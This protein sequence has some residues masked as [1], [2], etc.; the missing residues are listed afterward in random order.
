MF[1][2]WK[3]KKENGKFWYC[4]FLFSP[5]VEWEL[6]DQSRD[7][8]LPFSLQIYYERERII[9]LLTSYEESVFIQK[10]LI[11][12]VLPSNMLVLYYKAVTENRK[13]RTCSY[14]LK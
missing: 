6:N 12:H 2:A 5:F 11:S 8:F 13:H 9:L 10:G 3:S 1:G 14:Q 4:Y 7:L